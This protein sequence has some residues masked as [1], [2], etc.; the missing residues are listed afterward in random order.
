METAP[1]DTARLGLIGHWGGETVD[2]IDSVLLFKT[3]VACAAITDLTANYHSGPGTIISRIITSPNPTR[4]AW[5][6]I[7]TMTPD[8]Y[9]KN[10]PLYNAA[11][12]T[13]PLLVLTGEQDKQVATSQHHCLC[14][15][16]C[17]VWVKEHHAV[18]P[19]ERHVVL[20]KTHQQD[21]PV[22]AWLGYYSKGNRNRVGVKKMC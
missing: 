15:W 18:Y 1:V 6:S 22:A 2:V 11:G 10:A 13:T 5:V 20:E 17:G 14:I 19:G 8:R 21:L 12:I 9:L 4:C 16:R 3:A 7:F